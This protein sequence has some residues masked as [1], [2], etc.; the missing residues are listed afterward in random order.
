MEQDLMNKEVL[1]LLDTRQIQRFLFK[2]NSY[3][4]ALGGSDLVAEIQLEAIH[5][6]MTHIDPPLQEGEYAL[7]LD[8]DEEIPYFTSDKVQFQLLTCGA[9]NAMCIVRTGALCQKVIRK[10]S[11]YYLDHAYS[12]NLVASVTEKTDHFGTDIFHLYKKLN[13][14]KASADISDPLGPLSVV[15]REER[16]GQPAIAREPLTGEYYSRSSHLRREAATIR[17]EVVDMQQMQTATGFD[18]KEYLAVIHADGNNL[19]I[20]I[21]RIL[22]NTDSYRDGVWARRQISKNIRYIFDRSME[23][24]MEQVKAYYDTLDIPGKY[25]LKYAFHVC[26]QGGDDINI[27]CDARMAIPFLQFLYENLRGMKLWESETL[28]IPLYI[29]A[30]VAY[31]QKEKGFHSS[32]QLAVECCDSAKKVAKKA[33]NLRDGLAGNWIDFQVCDTVN[34]QELDFLREKS[35]ITKEQIHMQMRP[36]CL[37]PEAEEDAVSYSRFLE[38][39][40]S[41]QKANLTRQQLEALRLSYMMGRQEFRRW[42]RH[43]QNSGLDLT[44]L[45]GDALHR[46]ADGQLHALWFDSVEMIDFIP[47]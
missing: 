10:I 17:G 34:N 41:L 46:D 44:K 19:G 20:T 35:Y 25:D 47:E 9:G 23:L 30:G 6:A 1:C 32:Y 8:P 36:Y 21:G 38:R 37:D 26:H 40:R 45:L 24:T 7:S 3:M 16:T 13:A 14:I 15:V 28:S 5:Y 18:G 39:V 27:I 42:I 29:C 2:S 33:E 31:V 22:Q 4:D 11:R 12:L 43:S